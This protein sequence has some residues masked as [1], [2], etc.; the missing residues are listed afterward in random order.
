MPHHYSEAFRHI[1]TNVLFS[2]ADEG[3]KSLV[4]T[5]TG[6]CEGKSVVS[7]NIAISLALAGQRVLLI[8][9][10]MR[11]PKLHELFGVAA[12]PGLSNVIVGNAKASDAVK[13]TTTANLWLM[14]AGKT[15][16]NPA[17]LLGSK[18]FK[19]FLT[20]LHE[21][22]DWVIIDTPPVMAVTDA[23]VLAH[24]ATGVVFVVGAEMTGRGPAKA[25]LEQLDAAKA[26][27]LGGILNRVNV[28]RNAYYY[29]N[30]Y[31][32]EYTDYYTKPKAS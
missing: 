12:E 23:S 22:F 31:R 4:V 32:R 17:E 19:D 20:S 3:S 5:S 1:R 13:R 27:Y 9:A 21:H 18:R 2:S 28:Q 8:D 30:Q 6:P 16:P 10:D 26:K 29:A 24:I 11:R 25:A 14:V 15:P 7:S